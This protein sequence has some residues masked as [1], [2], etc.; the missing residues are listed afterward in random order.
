MPKCWRI[1]SLLVMGRTTAFRTNRCSSTNDNQYN[2]LMNRTQFKLYL[3]FSTII[4]A[5]A[6]VALLASGCKDQTPPPKIDRRQEND[7]RKIKNI[8]D[9]H[10][11]P[12]GF[13]IEKRLGDGWIVFSLNGN[14]YLYCRHG[15]YD[16]VTEVLAPYH[17]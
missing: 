7:E 15:E 17:E 5:G 13:K 6:I 11:L 1:Y 3:S 14:K 16:W 8:Y 12:E 2:K 10:L 9:Y 4:L